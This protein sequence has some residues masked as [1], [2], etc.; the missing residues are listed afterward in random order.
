[1]KKIYIVAMLLLVCVLLFSA[2]TAVSESE[3]NFDGE[4]LPYW[5]EY[6]GEKIASFTTECPVNNPNC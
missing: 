3:N 1:M 6:S 2:G 5:S 4:V